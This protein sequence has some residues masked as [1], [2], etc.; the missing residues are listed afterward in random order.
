MYKRQLE[1]RVLYLPEAE[2]TRTGAFAA[3][4]RHFGDNLKL[5]VGY[6]F[7]DFSDDLSDVT[8][9]DEGLFVNVIGKF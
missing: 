3:V 2:S 7:A 9:D 1:G 4:Y 6:N 5:G 8:F